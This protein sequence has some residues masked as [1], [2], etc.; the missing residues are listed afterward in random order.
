[1]WEEAAMS[2]DNSRS[3]NGLRVNANFYWKRR[4]R[5]EEEAAAGARELAANR[6]SWRRNY[7]DPNPAACNRARIGWRAAGPFS[8][9]ERGKRRSSARP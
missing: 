9:S 6:A 7:C 2:A 5:E 1:M 4:I 3:D 8:Q